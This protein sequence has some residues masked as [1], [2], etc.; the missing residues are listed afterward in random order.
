V[1]G[2]IGGAFFNVAVVNVSVATSLAEV[3]AF[4]I[5]E[6]GDESFALSVAVFNLHI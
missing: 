5:C 4:T 6:Y 3:D 2:Q 1:P